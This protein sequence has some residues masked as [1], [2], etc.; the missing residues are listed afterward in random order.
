MRYLD[1][2][3]FRVIAMRD[4]GYEEKSTYIHV[5]LPNPS[6]VTGGIASA[7]SNSAD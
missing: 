5:K 2:N 7:S 6:T 4:L 1:D 3:N